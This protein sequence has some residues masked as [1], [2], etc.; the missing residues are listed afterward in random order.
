M[1]TRSHLAL[2]D[3]MRARALRVAGIAII[4]L[5]AGAALLPAG[6]RISSDM[7]GGLLVAAGLIEAVAG[8][9]RSEVRPYAMTAGGVTALAGVLFII[10]PETHFFPTVTLIIAWLFIRSI[11]LAVAATELRG[12]VRTWTGLSAGM[13]F[14]LALLLVAG[15]SIT[16][17]V[18]S[19]FGPTRPLI[20]SF[21]WFVALSFVVNGMLLL[22][23]ASCESDSRD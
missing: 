15:L 19:I 1:D 22:E 17:I 4:L 23:I 9:L 8:S 6:K 3:R 16:T 5:S 13:D 2:S 18:V 20:A 7:I 14:L 10:N 12:S 11:I 21:A